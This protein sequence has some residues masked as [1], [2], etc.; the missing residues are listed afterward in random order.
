[1]PR[2]SNHRPVPAILPP[3]KMW[4]MPWASMTAP[5]PHRSTSRARLIESRSSIDAARYRD[6]PS[7]RAIGTLGPHAVSPKTIAKVLGVVT[8]ATAGR[9]RREGGQEARRRQSSGDRA[10]L[11]VEPQ[12][13]Q[14]GRGGRRRQGRR[15]VRRAPCPQGVRRRRPP[16]GAR[17]RLRA[18]DGGEHR[19]GPRQHEG[20]HDEARPDGQLPRPGPARARAPGPGRAAGE[21]AADERR[22][23]GPGRR[24]GAG[25]AARGRCSPPGTRS[26]SRRRRSVRCTAP[27]PTTAGPWPSRCSTRAS[28]MPSA[29][30]STTPAC[31]SAR[32]G[33]SS[34]GSSRSRSSPSCGSA[35]S[36]SSTTALEADNQRLFVEL[37]RG[38]PVHPRPRRASTS[39]ARERVLTTELAEGVRFDE[40]EQ[41]SQAERD[42]AAEAIFR[43]VFGSLYRLHAFNGDPHP[44]N[45]LFRPGGQVTFLDFGLVKRFDPDEVELIGAM[46]EGDGRRPRHHGVP[47]ADRGHRHA[48]ARQHVH[49]RRGAGLLRAL[50]R[51]RPARRG[52]HDHLGLRLGDGAS[53]L[54]RRPV[55]TARSCGRPTSRRRS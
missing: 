52:Q 40:V 27:S 29:P 46:L 41:W 26:R 30:T 11:V 54:R 31:C 18:A 23:G 38:P 22:A 5:M 24:G 4:L 2:L 36:R 32:C 51:L 16:R 42:L 39:S 7:R 10:D 35:S 17:C 8:A 28:A 9:P 50:L 3:P 44:G 20:R 48:G 43:F 12:R 13:P 25:Q 33:C 34:P 49:R 37:L 21:R 15:P 45:Y 47:P 55:R 6:R 14:R 1:M 19:G 53:V